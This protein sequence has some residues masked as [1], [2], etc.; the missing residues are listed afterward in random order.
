MENS[1]SKGNG[2]HFATD[3]STRVKWELPDR[4]GNE[5]TVVS[6]SD[7]QGFW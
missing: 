2:R 6:F 4:Q 1:A 7:D 3:G 5:V